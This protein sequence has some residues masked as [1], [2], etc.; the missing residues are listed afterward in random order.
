MLQKLLDYWYSL[1]FFQPCWPVKK[2]EDVNLNKLG[3]GVL[4]WL[5]ENPDLKTRWSFD[6]YFGHAIARDLIV[7]MLASIGQIE[8]NSPVER[9]QSDVCFCALKV[10]ERGAYVEGSFAVSGF[11][12]ALGRMVRFKDFGVKLDKRDLVRLQSE[13][14]SNLLEKGVLRIE[15]L[16]D[17]YSRVLKDIGVDDTCFANDLWARQKVQHQ[18]KDGSFPE[19]ESTTELVP[20]YYLEDIALVRKN[21]GLRV[22]RFTESLLSQPER[23]LIDSDSDA[24]Q[25]WLKADCFPWGTWPSVFSPSLMQQLAI[26]LATAKQELFSVNGPPGTGKTT[27]LKEVATA[28]IVQRARLMAEYL[29]P[30]DAFQKQEFASPPDNYNKTYYR[31]DGS[32]V[33]FGMLVA[34]N[35]NAAVENITIEL[36]KAISKGKDRT[37]RFANVEEVS[38]TYFADV[39]TA[40]LDEPAWGLISARLGRKKLRDNL[41]NRLWFA[42]EGSTLKQYYDNK[43]QPDWDE[44]KC[45]FLE[46]WKTVD[47]AR[48]GIAQAQSLIAEHARAVDAERVVDDRHGQ[49]EAAWKAQARL[50]EEEHAELVRLEESYTLFQQNVK[51]LKSGVSWFKRMFPLL[52]GEDIVVQAWRQA[53]RERGEALIEISRLRTSLHIRE[54]KLVEAEQKVRMYEEMLQNAREN[55]C[56]IEIDLAV[57]RERFGDNFAGESYWRDIQ[58]NEVS[59]TACPWTDESYDKLREELFYRALMLQKAFVLNSNCVKQ[60]LMRLFA[61]WDGRFGGE[62]RAA[63][64]GDLLNTLFFVIPVISTTFASVHS[65]LDGVQLGALGIL[66]VD[67]SGQATPQS[68]LGA[69]WRTQRAIVVGDPL[70]VEPIMTTPRELCKRFAKDSSLP[71]PYRAPELSVQILADA[72]N[73]FGGHREVCAE[74]LW[75]GCPL[76]VHR[77]CIDPMFKISNT[78]AYNDRMFCKTSLPSQGEEFLLDRSIWFD[79]GGAE[80]GGK[81]HTVPAQID[82]IEY[83]MQEAIEKFGGL[84]DLYIITPFT[85][86]KHAITERLRKLLSNA[87]PSSAKDEG[88]RWL[89]ERCG[90]IHTFQGKEA[91][92]VLLVLGCDEKGGKGA[93]AWV[94]QKPNIINVAV[95]R[96][97]YRIGV[98]GDY[99][100]WRR[101][102][103]V[104]ECA[105]KLERVSDSQ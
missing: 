58:M 96:A 4:P 103:Y 56:Q 84:P 60:N 101:I 104:E 51:L 68:A 21:P 10:D 8:E 79:V 5:Q 48:Q 54:Q 44:A 7:W 43:N 99:N 83:L 3:R 45:K 95:S 22:Q 11:V 15:D 53:E 39:A 62:D 40:L 72:Q 16:Q 76:V 94:G 78:V 41:K 27:L 105:N 34:S 20:S 25:Q 63:S 19:L 32:L 14:N 69:I 49:A 73:P 2:Y 89:S 98:I 18:K 91:N 17:L 50:Q 80:V 55:T 36:P 75:L 71:T 97:K 90:T 70:Q 92:E 42:K 31:P 23:V 29:K 86:V 82:K 33:A 47:E 1:E 24:M 88:N 61:L 66:I 6:V 30:D 102:P 28:N 52:F 38:N 57:Q 74:Q 12:W 93:A 59:Q 67:E 87:L 46:A 65:F 9:D 85:S 13:H 77:R 64:A 37:G 100:L 81:N 35:N 26:N